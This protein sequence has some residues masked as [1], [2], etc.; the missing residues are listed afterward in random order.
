MTEMNGLT[1]FYSQ[2]VCQAIEVRANNG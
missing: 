2:S 1:F